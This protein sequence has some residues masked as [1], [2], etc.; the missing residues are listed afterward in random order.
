MQD[1]SYIRDPVSGSFL[2][3]WDFLGLWTLLDDSWIFQELG[4][5][6]LTE[7]EV[8]KGLFGMTRFCGFS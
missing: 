4:E 2:K 8:M 5:E 7:F 6:K 1:F 3:L